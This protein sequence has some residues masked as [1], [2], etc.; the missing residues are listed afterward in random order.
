MVSLSKSAYITGFVFLVMAFVLTRGALLLFLPEPFASERELLRGVFVKA[1]FE[2]LPIFFLKELS[3]GDRGMILL[4]APFFLILGPT[5]LSL[6]LAPLC[7]SFVTFILSFFMLKNFVSPRAAIISSSLSVFSPFLY[8]REASFFNGTQGISLAL[9]VL[10]FY[11]FYSYLF[12][13]KRKRSL[14]GFGLASGLGF[15]LDPSVFPITLACLLTWVFL[16]P[17]TVGLIHVA[18]LTLSLGLGLLP[19][20]FLHSS[21]VTSLNFLDRFVSFHLMD[22][23]FPYEGGDLYLWAYAAI[24][25]SLLSLAMIQ[26]IIRFKKESWTISSPGG[27]TVI[28]TLP[29]F[30]SLFFS[31]LQNPAGGASSFVLFSLLFFFAMGIVIPLKMWGVFALGAL[32]SIG[33][34]GQLE[35]IKAEKVKA[36]SE[37]Q[38]YSFRELGL[39]LGVRYFDFPEAFDDFKLMASQIKDPDERRAVYQ[40]YSDAIVEKPYQERQLFQNAMLFPKEYRG[41]FWKALGRSLGSRYDS[42]LLDRIAKEERVFFKA[43]LAMSS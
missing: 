4:T 14:L 35:M 31:L 24:C 11:A 19:W 32:L 23:I 9:A 15:G 1:G 43:G 5:L 27:M 2:E 37:M 42:A 40:G 34:F 6:K 7:L 12:T 10:I 20:V 13:Q 22:K 21:D 33:G 25:F 29:I 39:E 3:V 41:Y 16:L 28:K 17:Q 8:I 38:G 26:Q 30:L 36:L 18:L